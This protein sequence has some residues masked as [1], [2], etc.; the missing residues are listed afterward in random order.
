[1]APAPSDAGRGLDFP[2][3]PFLSEESVPGAEGA[4]GGPEI[5]FPGH[6]LSKLSPSGGLTPSAA[7]LNL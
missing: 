5:N 1:M 7:E 4:G 6:P 3:G 2:S